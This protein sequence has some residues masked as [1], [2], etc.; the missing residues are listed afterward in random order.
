MRALQFWVLLLGSFIVSGLMMKEILLERD[1]NKRRQDLV[2]SQEIANSGPAFEN[3][4][5]QLAMRI[6]QNSKQ[7]QAM[8]DLLK[9]D[10]VQV[11]ANPTT[12]T[13]AQ[14]ATAA[15]LP[16]VPPKTSTP[17]AHPAGT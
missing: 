13:S 17:S 3:A 9:R 14:P 15:P 8:I 11:R 10:G 2:D 4:W 1:L 12:D 7:D 5:K 6:F 16:M